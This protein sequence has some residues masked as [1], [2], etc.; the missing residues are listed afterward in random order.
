M[1]RQFRQA[2][3]RQE[4]REAGGRGGAPRWPSPAPKLPV[5]RASGPWTWRVAGWRSARRWASRAC[6]CKCARSWMCLHQRRALRGFGTRGHEAVACPYS[7]RRNLASGAA[8]CCLPYLRRSFDPS[9]T[10]AAQTALS[11]CRNAFLCSPPAVRHAAQWAR[12]GEGD[13]YVV[14]DH[15]FDEVGAKAPV[16]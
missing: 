16:G 2:A 8:W 11:F 5:L 7:S 4:G 3:H 14:L 9:R 12:V 13:E 10:K 15:L 6:L 1:H